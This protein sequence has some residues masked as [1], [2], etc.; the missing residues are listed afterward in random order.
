MRRA[1]QPGDGHLVAVTGEVRAGRRSARCS[2]STA[3]AWTIADAIEVSR[4]GHVRSGSRT[5]PPTRSARAWDLKHAH[6]RRGDS[7]LRRHDR[8]RR[9]RPPPGVRRQDVAAPAMGVIRFMGWRDGTDRP[10]RGRPRDDAAARE[11]PRQGQLRSPRGA[12]A[13]PARIPQPRRAAVHPR[14][15]FVRRQRRP[16]AAGLRRPGAERRRRGRP[17]RGERRQARDVLAEL[18]MEPVVLEAKEGWRSPTGRR[19]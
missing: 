13:E 17:R 7:D 8:V 10:A 9:Q 3:P 6:D 4:R 18:G 14:A 12:R 19:S 15:R 2:S 5:A 11:L 16:G 1:Y